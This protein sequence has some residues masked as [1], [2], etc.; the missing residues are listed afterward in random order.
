MDCS[1]VLGDMGIGFPGSSFDSKN[2]KTYIKG[3]DLKHKYICGNHDNRGMCYGHP[4]FLGDY[5]YHEHSGIFYVGGGFSVDWEYREKHITW[6]ADEELSPGQMASCLKIYE[7]IKPKIVVSHE[8]PTEVKNFVITNPMKG[9][10]I[11]KTEKLLQKMVD[12]HR[13]NY[14]IFGHHHQ[15]KEVTL[16]GIEYNCLDTLNYGKYTDCI[17]EIPGVTWD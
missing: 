13:P 11:S 15:R 3:I 2:G 17:F 16:N 6:W 1:L 14:F 12:I 4:N 7:K 10:I 5:G 8:C 9:E